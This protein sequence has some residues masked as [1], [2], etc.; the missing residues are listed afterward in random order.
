MLPISIG[1][2][3]NW[4]S[5][6]STLMYLLQ[7]GIE[8]WK[9]STNSASSSSKSKILQI[10]FNSWQFE[11]YDSTKLTMIDTILDA[12]QSDI[13]DNKDFF[14][15]TD[16]FFVRIKYLKAGILILKKA[17]ENLTPQIIK[18]WMPSEEELDK[19]TGKDE[20][21]KL[22]DEVSDGNTSKVI[23]T[24]RKIFEGLIKDA[25]YKAV[26]VY[27]DDLD[28]CDPKRIIECLEAVK[29][30]VN[31]ERTAFIIGADERIIEYAIKLHYVCRGKLLRSGSS[32]QNRCCYESPSW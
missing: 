2:F 10:C 17:Y 18:K 21:K 15:K 23:E 8:Q 25:G 13:N 28:R 14:E 29:L 4:G 22:V 32:K 12:I 5:G 3:G 7:K 16:D 26:V 6:K 20:Y 27:I 1:V 30:F 19:I 31:V 24:F 11:S 9:L